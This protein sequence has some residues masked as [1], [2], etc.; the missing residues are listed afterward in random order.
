MFEMIEFRNIWCTLKD[1]RGDRVV[2]DDIHAAIMNFR[3]GIP[4]NLNCAE[5]LIKK[6]GV[7][8][9]IPVRTPWL[10]HQD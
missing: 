1:L 7:K 8:S 9:R 3:D 4:P 5:V 10:V 2:K 6:S